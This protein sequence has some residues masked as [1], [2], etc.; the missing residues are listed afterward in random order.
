[1]RV[2]TSDG[3]TATV[4]RSTVE[5]SALLTA[6]MR[7]VYDDDDELQAPVPLPNVSSRQLADISEFCE[8]QAAFRRATAGLRGDGRGLARAAREHGEWQEAFLEGMQDRVPGLMAAANYM[9]VE[10]LL[11]ACSTNITEFIKKRTPEEIRDYFKIR[12]R[13]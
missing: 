6:V 4:S 12:K 2:R 5:E 7:E 1:M 3:E 9:D 8:R 10:C 11:Q 13:R